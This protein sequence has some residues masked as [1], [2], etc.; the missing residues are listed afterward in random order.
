MFAGTLPFATHYVSE[1]AKELRQIHTKQSLS[2]LQQNWLSFCLTGMLLTETLCW[3]AFERMS[4]GCYRTAALSWMFRNSKLPWSDLLR[5]SV[6]LLLRILRLGHGVLVLDDS[7]HRRAKNTSRIYAAHKIFDK[8][9]GG[10]FN[11]QCLVFLLLVTDKV[12][13]PVGFCFYRP[14]TKYLDW[15]KKDERLKKEGVK[16]AERPKAPV[17]D[18]DYPSKNE[19]GLTL[20]N[21]HKIT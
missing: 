12:T 15:E 18:P 20:R 4:F 16:K 1:L 19:I 9:T 13:L 6:S 2:N 11:G 21:V 3:S 5:I 10:Y 8:K 17:P 14:D 7:D